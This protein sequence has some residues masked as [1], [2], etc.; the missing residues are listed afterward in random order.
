MPLLPN[1]S[2]R[3]AAVLPDRSAVILGAS[4]TLRRIGADGRAHWTIQQ[5]TET[6]AV[7]VSADG[8]LVVAA[9]SDGSIRWYRA[10]DGAALLSLLVLRDGRWVLWTESGHF[11]AGPGAEDLVGWL[12]TRPSGEQADYFGASRLRDRFL[13]PDVID[14]VLVQQ[15]LPRAIA[16]ANEA[17]IGL[18]QAQAQDDDLVGRLRAAQ[19]PVAVR[20]AVPAAL[21][22]AQAPPAQVPSTTVDVKVK[23]HALHRSAAAGA[24][25]AP[26]RTAGQRGAQARAHAAQRRDAGG[27]V[28]RAGQRRRSAA[29]RRAGTQRRVDAGGVRRAK[30]RARRCAKGHGRR[31]TSPRWASAATPTR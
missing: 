17:R 21:T 29:D 19:Q 4:R 1:E 25:G 31:C 5:P 9:L 2:T 26:G 3:A 12:V 30:Y 15:D 11:D 6:R 7:G 24:D 22:L 18:A 16:V 13:R 23:V 8:R 20:E 27:A 28:D 10:A 14:Q